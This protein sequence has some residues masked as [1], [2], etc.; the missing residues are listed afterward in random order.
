MSNSL[1]IS[2]IGDLEPL[3]LQFGLTDPKTVPDDLHDTLFGPP[4]PTPAEKAAGLEETEAKLYALLDATTIPNLADLLEQSGLPHKCLFQ[5]AEDEI[6][7][8]APWLVELQDGNRFTRNLFTL[9]EK[10]AA[11]W[12]LWNHQA[13]IYFR[14]RQDFTRLWRHLR[15]FTKLADRR[16]KWHLVRFWETPIFWAAVERRDPLVVEILTGLSSAIVMRDARARIAVAPNPAPPQPK[17][18]TE[19]TRKRL[20]LIWNAQKISAFLTKELPRQVRAYGADTADT[21]AFC[22]LVLDWCLRME[23]TGMRDVQRFAI[24]HCFLGL[25]FDRDLALT[26]DLRTQAIRDRIA[27]DGNAAENF[28]KHIRAHHADRLDLGARCRTA[29]QQLRPGTRYHD[30]YSRLIQQDGP[31]N[32]T[33]SLVAQLN[34]DI[35]GANFAAN[36]LVRNCLLVPTETGSVVETYDAL[37]AQIETQAERFDDRN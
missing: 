11:P 26:E 20:M 24:I 27:T 19:E 1:V 35:L 32:A 36:P 34:R 25:G 37:I 15:K 13:G 2:E 7:A 18:L 21:E 9:D 30:T 23:I 10:A 12:H 28:A 29:A 16:G 31:E 6:D 4:P 5:N 22:S 8:H 14:A 3:D 33:K 17:T